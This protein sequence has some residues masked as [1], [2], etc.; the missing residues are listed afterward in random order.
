MCMVTKRS[1]SSTSTCASV[2]YFNQTTRAYPIQCTT[3]GTLEPWTKNCNRVGSHNCK[4]LERTRERIIPRASSF[5]I[6]LRRRTSEPGNCF[7]CHGA[8]VIS[9]MECGGTGYTKNKNHHTHNPVNM[10]LIVGSKW[11]AMERVFGWRHFECKQKMN[12]AKRSYLLLVA[13][14]DDSARLWL[15]A[16]ILKSRNLWAAGWLQKSELVRLLEENERQ[17]TCQACH[18]AQHVPCNYCSLEHIGIPIE[19]F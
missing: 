5:S 4:M 10:Q 12:I 1:V 6:P 3:I 17:H 9:C 19:L 8:E 2:S 11:T 15:H 14:C 18:G 16:D 7:W 13:T